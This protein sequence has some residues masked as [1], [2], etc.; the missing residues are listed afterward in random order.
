MAQALPS[1]E[2]LLNHD[3]ESSRTSHRRRQAALQTLEIALGIEKPIHVVHSQTGH[4]PFARQA[5]HEGVRRL[6]DLGALDP[7]A[8]QEA[9][10]NQKLT[11][12]IDSR[13]ES[14]GAAAAAAGGSTLETILEALFTEQ[15]SAEALEAE[16]MRV[17]S[18]TSTNATQAQGDGAPAPPTIDAAA[19]TPSS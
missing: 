18:P 10:K 7:Q 14:A 16:R 12:L 8:D 19:S 11:R 9:L 4:L 13:R 6:E 17:T 3:V 15:F 2:D 1:R 5:Q